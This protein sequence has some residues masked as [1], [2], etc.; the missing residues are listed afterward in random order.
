LCPISQRTHRIRPSPHTLLRRGA[1]EASIMTAD[2]TSPIL[3]C[4][5]QSDSYLWM[6]GTDKSNLLLL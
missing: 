5:L 6:P 3:G 1:G 4:R 2:G